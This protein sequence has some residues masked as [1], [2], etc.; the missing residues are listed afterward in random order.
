MTLK[1]YGNIKY[2]FPLKSDDYKNRNIIFHG[3][4][5]EVEDVYNLLD[6]IINPVRCGAGLKIKNVEALGY[7]L[8][9]IT[10]THGAIGIEDGAT[11]AFLIANTFKQY[12]SAFE[13]LIKNFGIRQRLARDAFK[14][15]QNHLSREKCY[16][17]LL[18]IICS[19]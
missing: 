5:D 13:L 17:D 15:A 14:Y 11:E 6:I 9:L 18:R 3:F 4:V 7:G 8:P 10:S 2:S 1:I 12:L 19:T 16:S